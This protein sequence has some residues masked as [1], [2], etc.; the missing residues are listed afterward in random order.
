MTSLVEIYTKHRGKISDKWQSYLDTYDHDFLRF[1]DQ[2]ISLLEIGVQN[3]GSIEIFAQYFDR[4]AKIIGCDINPKCAQLRFSDSKIAILI[5]DADT[6]TT[7][8]EIASHS[9]EFDIIIDDGSHTQRDIVRSFARYFK[10]LRH[11]GLYVIEDLHTSYWQEYGGGLFHAH[12]SIA[13]FKRLV[14]VMNSEHWNNGMQ[15]HEFLRRQSN[16]FASPFDPETL[17]YIHSITFQNSLCVVRKMPEEANK[18]GR[19]IIAGVEC[20][21]QEFPAGVTNISPPQQFANP[22]SL[23]TSDP[24]ISRSSQDD[25]I[26]DLQ[27]Q[28]SVMSNSRSWR[29]T[30]PLRA[31]SQIARKIRH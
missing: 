13:F 14:D 1:R 21:V 6:D 22:L 2:A 10:R 27:H 28:I 11:G 29:M 15:L 17:A 16:Y 30:K 23:A 31:L 20:E 5:G 26:A 4:A 24:E 3:G 7:E 9:D 25:I 18:L 19:R 8:A 12:S